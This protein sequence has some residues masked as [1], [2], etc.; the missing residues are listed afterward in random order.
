[1][2][3][4]EEFEKRLN[5]LYMDIY[6][7]KISGDIIPVYFEAKAKLLPIKMYLSTILTP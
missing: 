3:N 1:M 6:F 2:I 5:S 4:I 7:S